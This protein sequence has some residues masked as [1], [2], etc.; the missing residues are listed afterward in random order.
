V[1]GER[2]SDAVR[3]TLRDAE[4]RSVVADPDADTLSPEID[5]ERVRAEAETVLLKVSE[6]MKLGLLLLGVPLPV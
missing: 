5:C 1:R 2:D 4:V 6:N 3:V